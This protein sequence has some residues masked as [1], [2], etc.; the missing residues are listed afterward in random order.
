MG[1][2]VVGVTIRDDLVGVDWA[3]LKADLAADNFDNGRTPEQLRES[4]ETACA[5]GWGL[6][7]RNRIIAREE[8]CS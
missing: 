3:R 8:P 2:V 1:G 6:G 4:F 7:P 5:A